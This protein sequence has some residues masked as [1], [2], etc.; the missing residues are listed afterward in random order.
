MDPIGVFDVGGGRLWRSRKGCANQSVFRDIDHLS[1][2]KTI[3]K[4]FCQA[5]SKLESDSCLPNS[6]G[7]RNCDAVAF[8]E[9]S[10]AFAVVRPASAQEARG[11]RQTG[12]RRSLQL[13]LSCFGMTRL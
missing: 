8:V 1:Q 3:P 7:V 10:L 13:R 6:F 5:S 9:Q 12:R 2:M 4:M 11:K